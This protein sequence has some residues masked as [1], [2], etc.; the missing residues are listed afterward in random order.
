MLFSGQLWREQNLKKLFCNNV[1]DFYVLFR[2]FLWPAFF[3]KITLH[4]E[5][6]ET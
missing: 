3:T 4:S 6:N 1:E 5:G 2:F